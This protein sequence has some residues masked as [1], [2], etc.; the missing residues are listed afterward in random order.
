MSRKKWIIFGLSVVF[1]TFLSQCKMPWKFSEKWLACDVV[2]ENIDFE[3]ENFSQIISK[4]LQYLGHGMQAIAFTTDDGK[5]VL[6][7]L[8]IKPIKGQKFFDHFICSKDPFFHGNNHKIKVQKVM[9]TYVRV[10][11]EMREETGLIG[12]HFYPT[13]KKWGQCE[14]VNRDGEYFQI[15]LDK[16]PF[17]LQL[18]GELLHS[19]FSNK[20]PEE[21]QILLKSFEEFLEARARKGY[22]D[23]NHAF[24]PQN[25][26]FI[27]SHPVMIDPGNLKYKESQ[28]QNPEPEIQR[29]QQL[30][31]KYINKIV[32]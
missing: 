29:I 32:Y 3:Y 31:H 24:K 23:P 8:T 10:Y 13:D 2:G 21:Y 15:D 19:A 25:Y 20:S 27:D 30:F 14:V 26:A 18:R 1:A 6:K 11:R 5:Y 17:I 9:Q 12:L 22:T 16:T 7:F 28:K 4:P